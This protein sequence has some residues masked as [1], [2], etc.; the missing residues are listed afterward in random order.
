MPLGVLLY[1]EKKWGKFL[2]NICLLYQQWKQCNKLYYQM[3]VR[4]KL[5]IPSFT[6]FLFG[7]DQLT[8]ARIRGTKILRDTQDKPTERFEG[9]LPI[10]E[11]WHARMALLKV[12]TYTCI[13]I[14]AILYKLS[15]VFTGII[16]TQVIWKRLYS[17]ASSLDKGTMYQLRN[18]INQT[19]VPTDPQNNMN[20]AEDFMLIVLHAHIVAAASLLMVWIMLRN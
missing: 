9:I 6:L 17:I 20:A 16:N 1:N 7:G 15:K 12:Y 13:Y 2:K 5:T 11:D 8:A 3:E 4:L 18:L 10:V 19:N 14:D